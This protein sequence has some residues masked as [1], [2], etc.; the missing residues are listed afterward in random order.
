[1]PNDAACKSNDDDHAGY[2][3]ASYDV[4]NDAAYDDEYDATNGNVP[5]DDVFNDAYGNEPN[6]AACK[7]YDVSNA[8]N[9]SNASYGNAYYDE[10]HDGKL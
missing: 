7:S 5:H 2:G 10:S 9:A 4:P 3:N 1:M 8:S 6:D